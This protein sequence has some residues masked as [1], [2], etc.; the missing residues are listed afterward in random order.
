MSALVPKMS[1]L[2]PKAD[3]GRCDW[4]VR[5]GP[6]ADIESGIRFTENPEYFSRG[7]PTTN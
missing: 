1:A 2:T 5:F 7:F 3:I 4:H 6:E